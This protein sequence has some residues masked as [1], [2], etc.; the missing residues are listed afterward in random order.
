MAERPAVSWNK[1]STASKILLVASAL[2]FIDL[3]LAWQKACGFGGCG[4]ATGW[5]G[6]GIL[7]GILVLA[8]LVMEVVT[9]LNVQVTM[10]TPQ[11]RSQVEA[12]LC[13]GVLLFTVKSCLT[14]FRIPLLESPILRAE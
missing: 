4:S 1:M 14:G 8:I 5:H 3:F 11:M 13:G 7:V 6:W 12:G 2:L 10:G 9:L